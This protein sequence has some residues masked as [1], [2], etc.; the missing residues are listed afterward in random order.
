MGRCDLRDDRRRERAGVSN[1][2]E[3][4]AAERQETE[5]AAAAQQAALVLAVELVDD[6]PPF[7]DEAAAD[8]AEGSEPQTEEV[9]HAARAV[10]SLR[11]AERRQEPRDAPDAELAHQ[12]SHAGK[13]RRAGIHGRAE[14]NYARVTETKRSPTHRATNTAPFS[15]GGG[16]SPV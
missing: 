5:E 7:V 15:S 6:G 11:H 14:P 13:I 4:E 10:D 16:D 8:H 2:L 12:R 9:G 3:P 1:L